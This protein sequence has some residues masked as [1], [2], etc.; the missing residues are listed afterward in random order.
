VQQ[1]IAL[2]LIA[3]PVNLPLILVRQYGMLG[4]LRFFKKE[5]TIIEA[6]ETGVRN[7]DLRLSS[8]WPELL[9]FAERFNF[10]KTDVDKEIEK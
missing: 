4:Y 1:A 7:L 5:S 3:E 2:S 9:A 10:E 6:K 8:A